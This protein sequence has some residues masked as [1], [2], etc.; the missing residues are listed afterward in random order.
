MAVAKKETTESEAFSLDKRVVVRNIADWDANFA[1][2]ADGVG[3]VR[4]VPGGT[5]MLSRNEIIAQVQTGNTLLAGIDGKGSHANLY[6]EDEATRRHVGFESD[7]QPQN[8]LTDDKVKKLFSIQKQDEYEK[9]FAQEI[10]T[11]AEGKALMNAVKR[12]GL[13]DYGKIR[14]AEKRTGFTYE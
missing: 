12:L 14:F 2:V 13:N 1:R 5:V 7:G 10:V 11:R 8:I 6:I 4:I 3:D 9:A